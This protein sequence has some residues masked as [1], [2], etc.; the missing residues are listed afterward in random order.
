M[1]LPVPG[2]STG[3]RGDFRSAWMLYHFVGRSFSSRRNFVRF[4]SDGAMRASFGALT[5]THDRVEWPHGA[6]AP[7][8][9]RRRN[10]RVV[11]AL[12]AARDHAADGADHQP[13]RDGGRP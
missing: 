10:A 5:I 11:H 4:L 3:G 8:A 12:R 13:H 9:T 2:W 6:H 1:G 7:V